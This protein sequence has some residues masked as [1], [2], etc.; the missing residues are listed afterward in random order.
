[1][2][3]APIVLKINVPNHSL[4]KLKLA[5]GAS[6]SM[7]FVTLT[8]ITNSKCAGVYGSDTVISSC[9]CTAAD[10]RKSTCSV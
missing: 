1:M 7:M 9:I 4:R 3:R 5:G 2:E 10:A 8:V 6:A